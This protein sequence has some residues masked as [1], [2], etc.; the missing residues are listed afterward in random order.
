MNGENNNYNQFANNNQSTAPVKN[1][2]FSEDLFNDVNVNDVGTSTNGRVINWGVGKKINNDVT[3]NSL[4]NSEKLFNFGESEKLFNFGEKETNEVDIYDDIEV[5]SDDMLD[6]V[7]AV[8]YSEEQPEVLDIYDNQNSYNNINVITNTNLNSNN[9]FNSL[10]SNSYTSNN[11]FFNQNSQTNNNYDMNSNPTNSNFQ[12]H[13]TNV[14]SSNSASIVNA[15]NSSSSNCIHNFQ[16]QSSTENSNEDLVSKFSIN[17]KFLKN[18]ML[19]ENF[20]VIQ[21]QND[22]QKQNLISDVVEEE[23]VI[24]KQLTELYKDF[25]GGKFQKFNMSPFSFSF[26]I[27]SSTYLFYRKMY[28]FGFILFFIENFI[29]NINIL[30]FVVVFIVRLILALFVNTIYLKFSL[31]KVKELVNKNPNINFMQMKELCS[32]TGGTSLI[33]S[34]LMI[35]CVSIGMNFILSFLQIKSPFEPLGFIFQETQ[36]NGELIYDDYDLDSKLNVSIPLDYI[37][38]SD[39]SHVFTTDS[40]GVFNQCSVSVRSVKG[41]SSS[42]KLISQMA[43]YDNLSD[44]IEILNNGY[45]D[46]YSFEKEYNFGREYYRAID[47]EKKVILFTFSIGKDTPEGVCDNHLDYVFSSISLKED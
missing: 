28:L 9:L 16:Q 44:K 25:V 14:I 8:V 41:Y 21:E 37:S 43:E 23:K 19:P 18:E 4:S 34:I 39:G 38:D 12:N 42:K 35:L 5:L 10:N 36:Y 30:G 22:L 17:S 6:D 31:K 2:F 47:L 40:A 27:F 45:F 1:K 33:I 15:F 13:N 7:N 46:W 11:K 26:F 20:K 32:K 24:D 29:I 3:N